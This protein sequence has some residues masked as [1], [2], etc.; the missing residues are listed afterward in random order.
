MSPEEIG[1]H[2]ESLVKTIATRLG[3]NPDYSPICSGT[4]LTIND[5]MLVTTEM[6]HGVNVQVFELSMWQS[7]TGRTAARKH[8]IGHFANHGVDP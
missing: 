1:K 3:D 2:F 4:K 7:F 6:L 5:V 8:H